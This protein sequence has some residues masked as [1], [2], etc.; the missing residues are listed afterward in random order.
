MPAAA[1]VERD[2]DEA[3]EHYLHEIRQIPLLT[4]AEEVVL[5]RA[6]MEGQHARKELLQPEPPAQRGELLRR[7]HRGDIA[8]A[9]LIEANLRLVVSIAK[10]YLGYGLPLLDLVQEGNLGLMRAVEKFDYRRGFKF[11]TYATWWIRQSVG[12]AVMDQARTVR[13]PVPLQ[14]RLR[15]LDRAERTLLQDL[16]REIGID[17]LA[18]AVGAEVAEIQR[19]RQQAEAVVSLD[20]PT[21]EEDDGAVV[22]D[23]VADQGPPLEEVA[24]A[25]ERRRLVEIVL[26]QLPSREALVLRLRYGFVD[27][28]RWTLDEIGQRLGITRERVRQ[29]EADALRRL[30][31]PLFAQF[32]KAFAD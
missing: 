30:R 26:E 20:A 3:L 27:D 19:V 31:H 14:E 2:R 17:E 21:R 18:A 1:S 16:G 9:R 10:R 29:I 13:L 23:R 15:Q 8:R 24:E 12:R 25:E 22:G 28:R 6:V 4:A 5:G 7:A 32:L 11:S